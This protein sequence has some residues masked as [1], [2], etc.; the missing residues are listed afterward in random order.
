MLVVRDA[1]ADLVALFRSVH[2]YSG[3][4]CLAIEVYAP[5]VRVG[6]VVNLSTFRFNNALTLME[7]AEDPVKGGEDVRRGTIPTEKEARW[8]YR[9][10]RCAQI[11]IAPPDNSPSKEATH[12]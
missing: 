10:R 8:T 9:G 5:T 11:A 6:A 3:F 4:L 12:P 7:R 2:G 1:V